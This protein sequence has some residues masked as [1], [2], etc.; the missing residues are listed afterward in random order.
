MRSWWHC[1]AARR[2]DHELEEHGG[3]LQELVQ[4][5]PALEGRAHAVVR[6]VRLAPLLSAAG[7]LQA[8]AGVCAG[9]GA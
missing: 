4:M 3:G 9:A 7:A 2:E 1:L 5:R 6:V 8:Y